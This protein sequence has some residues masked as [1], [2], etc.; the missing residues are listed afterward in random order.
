MLFSSNR[1]PYEPEDV[2]VVFKDDGTADIA[3]IVT[4]N[5]ERVFAESPQGNYSVPVEDVKSFVGRKGRIFLYPSTIEN[6]T[7]CQRIA[8]LERSTVLRSITHFEEDSSLPK[9]P[10]PMGKIIIGIAVAVLLI[11]I[12]KAV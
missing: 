5:D 10:L 4:M 6:V 11:I 7:D 2:L 3:P 9:K 12:L 8:A 1:E